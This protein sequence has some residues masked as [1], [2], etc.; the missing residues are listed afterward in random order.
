MFPSK[1]L[2]AQI[3]FKGMEGMVLKYGTHIFCDIPNHT[4]LEKQVIHFCIYRA[5]EDT[6]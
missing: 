6:S 2:D 5:L 1:A 4:P 3:N